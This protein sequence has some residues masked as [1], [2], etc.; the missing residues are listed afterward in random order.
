MAIGTTT[1]VHDGKTD[2]LQ[3]FMRGPLL[4]GNDFPKYT[5][6]HYSFRFV[7]HVGND[8]SSDLFAVADLTA[9]FLI[10]AENALAL[11]GV[12]QAREST[13]GRFGWLV[14]VNKQPIHFACGAE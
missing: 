8:S 6:S 10:R 3:L 1:C 12:S 7:S 4:P 9:D 14:P 5:E 2:L 11:F 13:I